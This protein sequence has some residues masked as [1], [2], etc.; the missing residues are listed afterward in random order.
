MSSLSNVF[1]EKISSGEM[2]EG[3]AWR[4]SCDRD[5]YTVTWT[6]GGLRITSSFGEGGV[7]VG[8]DR[9]KMIKQG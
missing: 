9:Y 1:I 2:F 6:E 8:Q 7:Q 3:L 5:F 4:K